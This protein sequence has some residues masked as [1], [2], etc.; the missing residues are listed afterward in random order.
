MKS[1]ESSERVKYIEKELVLET[2][3]MKEI[4][5][6]LEKDKKAIQVAPF[7]GKILSQLVRMRNP[8]NVVEIGTLYGYSLNWILEGVDSQAKVWSVE[9]SAENFDKSIKF[10]NTHDKVSQVTIVNKSGL[11]FLNNWPQE[12]SIDFLFIDADKGNYLNYLNLAK[13][14][15]SKGAVVVG[16]NTFLFGHVLSD[17]PPEKYS[18]NTWKHMREFNEVLNGSTGEFSGMMIPTLQGLTVGIKNR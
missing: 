17:T 10:T 18:K 4:A 14:Y 5:L 12:L 9:N 6:E 8:E 13:P 1:L 7:E 11:D 16:D 3:L 15:L 2:S